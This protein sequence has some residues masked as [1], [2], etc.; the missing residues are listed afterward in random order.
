MKTCK[1]EKSVEKILKILNRKWLEQK[2]IDQL[3]NQNVLLVK[4]KSQDL[5][6]NK[7]QKVY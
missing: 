5:L 3:C 1:K 6:K 2:I 7:K 4:L